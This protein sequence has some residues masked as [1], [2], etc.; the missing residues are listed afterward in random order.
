[1]LSDCLSS[2]LLTL[3]RLIYRS[4]GVLCGSLV[5]RAVDIKLPLDR[6]SRYL[7]SF[8]VEMSENGFFNRIPFLCQLFIPISIPAAKLSELLCPF[9]S[10]SH[11]LFL[12]HPGLATMAVCRVISTDASLSVFTSR[13]DASAVLAVVVCLSVRPSV[14][15]RG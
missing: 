8:A 13:R 15:S 14:T 12:F 2:A 4:R 9:L 11:R 5:G 6:L 1:M 7:L 10:Q 3:P